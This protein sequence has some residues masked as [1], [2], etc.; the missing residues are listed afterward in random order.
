[1]GQTGEQKAEDFIGLDDIYTD[2]SNYGLSRS[3][4]AFHLQRMVRFGLV[5]P[6]SGSRDVSTFEPENPCA[7]TKCG[8]YYLS[9][10]YAQFNYFSAVACDTTIS[11]PE[12]VND[13]ERLLRDNMSSDKIPLSI[14][15]KIAL[16]FLRYLESC[17]NAEMRGAMCKHPIVGG[18][19]FVPKMEQAYSMILAAMPQ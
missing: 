1:M 4:I 17:E 16:S 5:V 7:L 19:R 14:R 6:E 3:E 2:F 9:T 18:V 8:I 10:L 13:I 12:T 15:M 11:N